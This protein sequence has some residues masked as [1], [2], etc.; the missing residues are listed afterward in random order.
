M[1]RLVERVTDCLPFRTRIPKD[2]IVNGSSLC[3][4]SHPGLQQLSSHSTY[5]S[6]SLLTE[7]KRP[8]RNTSAA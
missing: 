4:E 1:L 5:V 6:L 3:G 7:L 8:R 2:R